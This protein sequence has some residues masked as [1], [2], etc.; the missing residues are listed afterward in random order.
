MTAKKTAA[1]T[2]A[3]ATTDQTAKPVETEA[4]ASPVSDQATGQGDVAKPEAGNTPEHPPEDNKPAVTAGV[5]WVNR[6]LLEHD[7]DAY[8][9]GDDI[10]LSDDQARPLRAIGAVL[11]PEGE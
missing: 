11:M 10:E 4:A 9:Q 7:G 6:E 2:A 1:K 3:D 5:Y 8:H